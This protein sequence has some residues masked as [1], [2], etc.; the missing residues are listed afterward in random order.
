MPRSDR[1]GRLSALRHFKVGIIGLLALSLAAPVSAASIP[2][3]H[4]SCVILLHGLWR[5]EYSMKYLEWG[6]SEM[7]FE[8]VNLT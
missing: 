1:G 3:R 7:E 6:L 4:E 5:T 8:V 2:L